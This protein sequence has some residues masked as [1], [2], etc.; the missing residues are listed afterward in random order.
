MRGGVMAGMHQITLMG[1]EMDTYTT[2]R[3]KC[4]RR[5]VETINKEGIGLILKKQN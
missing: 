4:G 1:A 5:M 3:R 2:N